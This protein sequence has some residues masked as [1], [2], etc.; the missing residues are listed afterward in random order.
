MSD[1][2]ISTLN[3]FCLYSIFEQIQKNCEKDQRN[4]PDIIRYKDIIYLAITNDQFHSLFRCWNRRLYERL[5]VAKVYS[6]TCQ[7]LSINF[8]ELQISQMKSTTAAREAFWDIFITALSD[9]SRVRE[10]FL[11][12]KPMSYCADHVE[13]FELTMRV[14]QKKKSLIKLALQMLSYTPEHLGNFRNLQSLLLDVQMDADDLKECL[15][16]NPNIIELE[17][18]STVIYGR[19]ADITPYCWNLERL[20]FHI[21]P[22]T[23]ANEYGPLTKLPKLKALSI[24]GYPKVGSLKTL[25]SEMVSNQ[26]SVLQ[27]LSVQQAML[28]PAAV[29]ALS[30]M[31]SLHRL[32]CELEPTR[33][34]E[35]PGLIELPTICAISLEM[36]SSEDI[37][38][39][40]SNFDI[41][42]NRGKLALVVK[43]NRDKDFIL[44]MLLRLNNW[45]NNCKNQPNPLL[46]EKQ[47]LMREFLQINVINEPKR[48]EKI[49]A[50]SLL[51]AFQSQFSIHVNNIHL[52]TK[53]KEL[54][55]LEVKVKLNIEEELRQLIVTNEFFCVGDIEKEIVLEPETQE[56]IALAQLTY[57][58]EILG[59][60]KFSKIENDI[61]IRNYELELNFDIRP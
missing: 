33:S 30:K 18:A 58:K 53:I 11:S 55:Q 59:H 56:I 19:L 16:S 3:Q 26:L 10:C 47:K 7:V 42:V 31:N 1:T 5:E 4:I 9:N 32:R 38:L 51:E 25:F 54:K 24:F 13:R 44:N 48:I 28:E 52:L 49:V 40:Y 14:L 45:H 22:E 34:L 12:Y 27:E 61:A 46:F 41:L 43:K 6:W 17:F 60:S 50:I 35:S 8:Y 37:S 36:E 39:D 2:S 20:T 21:K 23:N 29:E 57:L 15:K